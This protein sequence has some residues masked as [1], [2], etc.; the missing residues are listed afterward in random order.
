MVYD[1]YNAL[2]VGFCPNER[3]SDGVFSI[4]VYPQSVALCFL[5]GAGITDPDRLL[6][7]SGT[8]ARHIRLEDAKDLEKPVVRDLIGRAMKSARVQFNSAERGKLV[9]CSISAKQR[10]RRPGK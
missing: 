8:V 7:G 10:P 5:Q 1:N 4:A 3:P 2:V 9:I 6:Q